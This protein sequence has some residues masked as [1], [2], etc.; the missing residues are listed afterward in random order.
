M[1]LTEID[2]KILKKQLLEFEKR[3]EE[4]ETEVK[5]LSAYVDTQLMKKYYP[6]VQ[7][8]LSKALKPFGAIGER[9]KALGEIPCY[10]E[11]LSEED[12]LK[13]MSVVCYCKRCTARSTI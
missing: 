10:F 4:V 13:P 11:S 2:F 6:S 9:S 7:A 5:I 8:D 1:S 12:K 3:L